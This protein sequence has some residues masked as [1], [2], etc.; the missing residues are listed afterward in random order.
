M[1]AVLRNENIPAIP[2][3]RKSVT[4]EITTITQRSRR[5]RRV[6]SKLS[7]EMKSDFFI[8]FQSDSSLLIAEIGYT[9]IRMKKKNTSIQKLIAAM[10][11]E[12]SVLII[13]I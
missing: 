9:H 1:I 3:I 2:G 5:T 4:T 6:K 7:K 10:N 11:T 8:T 12:M 13:N